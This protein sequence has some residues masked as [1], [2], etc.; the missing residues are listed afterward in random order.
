VS[1][2]ISLIG[3][4]GRGA[5]AE[6]VAGLRELIRGITGDHRAW[7]DERVVD[8]LVLHGVL[9]GGALALLVAV[10]AP[11]VVVGA[12]VV[13]VAVLVPGVVVWCVRVVRAARRR[14]RVRWALVA[15]AGALLVAA[16]VATD[17]PLAARWDLSRG[18]FEAHLRDL[19]AEPAP[20]ADWVDLE[21]PSRLG[22]Y[23]VT[24]AERVPGGVVFHEADGAGFDSAGFAYLPAGP[25]PALDTGWFENPQFRPLGGPWY[26]WTASW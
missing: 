7:Q 11:G 23:R 18:S 17:A 2:Q 21:V 24:G 5:L 25:T 1:G 10:S 16:L 14:E 13:A 6:H 15:P 20:D 22:L 3:A 9:A 4:G 19:P 26:A 12:L 8:R